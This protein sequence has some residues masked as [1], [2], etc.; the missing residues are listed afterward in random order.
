MRCEFPAFGGWKKTEHIK[1][2]K[3]NQQKSSFLRLVVFFL[4]FTAK[5]DFCLVYLFI[6][7]LSVQLVHKVPSVTLG[8]LVSHFL[9]VP[10]S[11]FLPVRESSRHFPRICLTVLMM[12]SIIGDSNVID[13]MTSFNMASREVMQK[14]HFKLTLKRSR[15][16]CKIQ[17]KYLFMFVKNTAFNA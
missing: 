12:F 16:F 10:F 13:N 3:K 7:M 8:F 4:F 2:K 17:P 14:A 15:R 1:L 11:H 5:K 6:R 9:P